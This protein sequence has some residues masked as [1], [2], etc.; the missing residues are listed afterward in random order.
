M[1][2][3]LIIA[4][5]SAKYCRFHWDFGLKYRSRFYYIAFETKKVNAVYAALTFSAINIDTVYVALMS[6]VLDFGIVYVA[7]AFYVMNL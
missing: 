3:W 4:F 2:V 7:L 1:V 5:R 6:Y